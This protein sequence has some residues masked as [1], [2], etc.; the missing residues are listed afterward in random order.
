MK[1]VIFDLTTDIPA[2]YPVETHDPKSSK[3]KAND[4]QAPGSSDP[5]I[6]RK[7]PEPE[8]K[9]T[10]MR[11]LLQLRGELK[12]SRRIIAQQEASYKEA[13]Q[14]LARHPRYMPSFFAE[15]IRMKASTILTKAVTDNE[16]CMTINAKLCTV[17]SEG[18]STWMANMVMGFLTPILGAIKAKQD[19]EAAVTAH[20]NFVDS[21][22]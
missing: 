5:V 1:G 22:Q 13:Q 18:R 9:S 19:L 12:A 7:S 20:D 10:F 4:P 2:L 6:T 17:A 14:I 15:E 3:E 21:L 11:T 16:P 8:V